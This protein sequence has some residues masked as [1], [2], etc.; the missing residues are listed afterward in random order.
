MNRELIATMS[1]SIAASVPEV[2]E[3]LVNP[4]I[5]SQ[6]YH[7][8]QTE[9]TWKLHDPITFRGEWKGVPYVDKGQIVDIIPE[10][11]LSYTYWSP[12]SGTD[13]FEDNYARITFHVSAYDDDTTLNVIQDNIKTEEEVE[14][15]EANWSETLHKIKEILELKHH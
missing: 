2:W 1:V 9:T 4:E 13:D 12:L 14:K 5:I 10:R 6:Y 8:T 3:A 15:A 11:I 7:G